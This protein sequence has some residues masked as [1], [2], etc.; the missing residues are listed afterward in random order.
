M[1]KS[2]GFLLQSK[3]S[4]TQQE[5]QV[6]VKQKETF[7]TTCTYQIPTF[8]ALYW[9]QQKKGQAPQLVT[10]HT[11]AG[12][13][14]SGR[15]TTGLNTVGKSSILRLKEVE[16]SD[17]ALYLCAVRDTLVQGATLA[18]Q[19]PRMGRGCQ[20]GREGRQEEEHGEK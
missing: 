18:V 15:F 7:Q 20:P 1:P 6:T 9:Y 11:E 10:Y 13:K 3:T 12:T 2:M 14:Q 17:S 8:Y 19:Q 5:G 4:V 16:L